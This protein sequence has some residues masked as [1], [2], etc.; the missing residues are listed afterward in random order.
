[1]ADTLVVVSKVKD[2]VRSVAGEDFRTGGDFIE[3]L[4]RA[5][6]GITRTAIKR[7]QAEGR[8]T[9]KADDV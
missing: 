7:A 2:L 8:K 6:E 4:S 1:M 3:E 5:V 9:V